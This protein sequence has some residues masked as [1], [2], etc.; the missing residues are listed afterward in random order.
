MT[1][2]R[3]STT[4]RASGIR[5]MVSIGG[6][7]YTDA[8]NQ[9]L[10]QNATLL[11]QRAAAL[12]TAARRRRRDRLRGEHEP[13]PHGPPGLHR[14]LSGGSSLR[15]DRQ[16]SRR[17]AD[18]RHRRRRP[19]ADRDQPQGDGRLAADRRT[20][21]RLRQ[22]DGPG[23][24]TERQ[25]GDRELAGAHRRQAAIRAAGP[26]AGA[27]QV[28]RVALCRRGLAVSGRSATTTAPR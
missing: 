13:E 3:S 21:P 9:A 24:P 2:G 6:I 19:L 26:A 23:A 7:T 27:G 16:R 12:A 25:H 18:D 28:H 11:G 5:V 4:S 10:A 15:R 22:R 17:A 1:R 8:W 14:R 20:G